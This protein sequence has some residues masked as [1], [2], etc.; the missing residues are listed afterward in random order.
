M[1]KIEEKA[2]ILGWVFYSYIL[3]D[4]TIGFNLESGELVWELGDKI[5]RVD[6]D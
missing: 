1:H 5:V 4:L 2:G 3:I 6:G